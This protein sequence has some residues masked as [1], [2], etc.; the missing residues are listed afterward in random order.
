MSTNYKILIIDDEPDIVELLVD[1]FEFAGFQVELAYSGNDGIE[2]LKQQS[3]DVVLS[4][5]KMPNGDGKKVYEFIQSQ[6]LNL[7]FVLLSGNVN[8]NEVGIFKNKSVLFFSKPFNVDEI[9]EK[10]TNLLKSRN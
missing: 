2:I 6:D 1:G 9:I 3:F 4:D 8:L 10:V 7:I 5:Y